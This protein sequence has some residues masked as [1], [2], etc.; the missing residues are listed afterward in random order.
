[1]L[2]T[3]P[4]FILFEVLQ[5]GTP[6]IS[7]HR[8]GAA[9][10]Q[11]WP[12][13]G[14]ALK[15]PA[16]TVLQLYSVSFYLLFATVF[17]VLGWGL[18]QYAFGLMLLLY[19]TLIVSDT[20]FWP[21]NEIHQAT[22][23]GLLFLGYYFHLRPRPRRK[24]WQHLVLVGLL[25]LA[26]NTHLLVAAPLSLLW[27]AWLWYTIDGRPRE[28]GKRD[29]VYT[30]LLLLGIGLRYAMSR[31][32]WYDGYKLRGVKNLSLEA[33]S[34]SFTSGQL[35]TMLE[36]SEGY[37]PLLLV[38][39]AGVYA[40]VRAR[41]YGVLLLSLAA[42]VAYVV[43]VTVTYPQAF[44]R[45][46]LYYFESEWMGLGLVLSVP[47]AAYLEQL[48]GYVV[49]GLLI[50]VF[51]VRGYTLV[52]SYAYFHAR[53]ENLERVVD[54]LEVNDTRL[55]I[56]EPSQDWRPYFGISWGLPLETLWL[57]ALDG[58]PLSFK[59]VDGPGELA[60]P[61]GE[62]RSDFKRMPLRSLDRHYFGSWPASSYRVLTEDEK[63]ELYELL[64]PL[65]D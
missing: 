47:L 26:T 50:T 56:T 65:P 10:T 17:A 18:R 8:Y 29:G 2:F 41:R 15:L 9:L 51:V 31:E 59:I 4:S 38:L 21:N 11:V 25:L 53:T 1:M 32:S 57:S 30:F 6:I 33:V 49:V 23:L 39:A 14:F 22:A 45:D 42:S 3:D 13:L 61:A 60:T 5:A 20:Y 46:Q 55:A 54:Y 19:L 52:G 27:V 62:F 40:S 58:A 37:W 48:R 16:P 44:G 7:E 28:L 63:L 64:R 12:L 35:R 36:Y 43:L 24:L 34:G